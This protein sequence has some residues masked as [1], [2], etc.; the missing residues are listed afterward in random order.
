MKLSLKVLMLVFSLAISACTLRPITVTPMI[1]VELPEL[2]PEFPAPELNPE[3]GPVFDLYV[4]NTGN[5][6]DNDCRSEAEPCL[7]INYAMTESQAL[8]AVHLH[9]GPGAY[10]LD[11]HT[12]LIENRMLITG[13]GRGST[14]IDGLGVYATFGIASTS[15]VII[16]DLTVSNAMYCAWAFDT[17][18]AAITIR[19]I[20]FL[21]CGDTSV[22]NEGAGQ[23][24][25]QNVTIRAGAGPGLSNHGMLTMENVEIT[26]S[27]QM[28]IINFDSGDLSMTG[29]LISNSGSHGIQNEGALSVS[30]TLINNNA[31][32]GLH[33]S[34]GLARLEAVVLSDQTPGG[35]DGRAN[36]IYALGDIE[37]AGS[38]ISGN[39][40]G[41]R[42]IGSSTLTL[43][44]S[45]ILNQSHSGLTLGPDST[46]SLNE[47]T[48]EGNATT[49]GPV[50]QNAGELTINRSIIRRNHHITLLNIGIVNVLDSEFRGNENT[51]DMAL[52]LNGDTGVMEVA[53]TLFAENRV[54]DLRHVLDNTGNLTLENVTFSGNLGNALRGFR[55]TAI[56]YSTFADNT[57]YGLYFEGS[58]PKQVDNVL[59]ARNGAGDCPVPLDQ[60]SPVSFTG[61][62]I[63]SDD[64]CGFE[65]TLAPPELLLGPLADNGG[66]TMTHEL[67]AGSPA[68]DA[69]TG[70][71]PA[72]DQRTVSRPIAAG[73]DVG[74]FEAGGTI[75]SIVIGSPEGLELDGFTD[76]AAQPDGDTLI[77][78]TDSGCFFGPGEA[79]LRVSTLAAGTQALIVGQGIG[80]GWMVVTHPTVNTNCWIDIDD[81]EFEIPLDL[82]RLISIPPKPTGTPTATKEPSE[83]KEPR[84]TAEPNAVPTVCFIDQNGALIC[85]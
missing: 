42:L 85:K 48:I 70:A 71:C 32:S 8:G 49:E 67:L 55:E 45:Q 46:A 50:M 76:D 53:R 82:L 37:I 62:N 31:G 15:S 30:G 20:D 51:L 56:S 73:C 77:V 3:V 16:E 59:F 40:F 11:R 5:D 80:G 38:V 1:S 12:N 21:N 69:A 22:S 25:L 18:T 41:I 36:G 9:I 24:L 29:G 14:L 58:V 79:W 27:G 66:A 81:V 39:E 47:V 64:T 74:A 23:F 17:A 54:Q 35:T 2:E 43:N 78:T 65:T 34:F 44:H 72:D 33:H 68:I 61:V 10:D 63:D 13:A 60:Q 19:R 75:A 4:A 6:E 84:E 28:G 7:T 52:M 26:G 83:P 57:G